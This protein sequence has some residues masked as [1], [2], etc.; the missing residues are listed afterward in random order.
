[1]KKITIAFTVAFIAAAGLLH[2]QPNPLVNFDTYEKLLKTVK[3]YR[4][5]RL[6]SKTTFLQYA[7]EK[8]TIILDTRSKAMY[9]MKHI[10]GAV[11]LNFSDFSQ[12]ALRRI[13]P[14]DSTRILIYCNNN[15]YDDQVN[16]V[17]KSYR[18]PVLGRR[19][20]FNND[21]TITL[22]LNIPTF[23]NLYGYGYRNIY[24][25]KDLVSAFDDEIGFEGTA[26]F[27]PVVVK[28]AQR[29]SK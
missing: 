18:P 21:E 14:N 1:M 5:D 28:A 16:Y 17:S 27:K 20:P 25:L 8:N 7:K 10:K 26:V 2:A 4:T 22:A 15:F 24:E 9:D 11:H 12:D 29:V 13:I 23:I 19:N 3:T 6:L